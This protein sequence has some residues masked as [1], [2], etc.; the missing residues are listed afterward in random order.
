M[1]STN[2]VLALFVGL[3][4]VIL[5]IGVGMSR[6][7]KNNKSFSGALGSIFSQKKTVRLTPT[8]GVT[9]V[10][11]KNPLVIRSNQT[12]SLNTKTTKS[13]ILLSTTKGQIPTEIP[14]TGAETVPIIAFSLVFGALALK[15]TYS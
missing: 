3:F 5:T 14:Q 12:G 10:K 9:T 15:K 1:D 7:T 6:M 11:K 13:G 4:V 2:K 8:T